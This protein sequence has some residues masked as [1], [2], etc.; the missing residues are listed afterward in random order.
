MKLTL[1]DHESLIG[2]KTFTLNIEQYEF[3]GSVDLFA[4]VL[5]FNEVFVSI[6]VNNSATVVVRLEEQAFKIWI[7]GYCDY[8]DVGFKDVDHLFRSEWVKEG[9]WTEV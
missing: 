1:T 2:A 9:V 8:N 4:D 7:N 5:L 6:P 3:N